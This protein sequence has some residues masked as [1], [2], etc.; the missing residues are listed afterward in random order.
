MYTMLLLEGII[1]DCYWIAYDYEPLKGTISGN[2]HGADPTPYSKSTK[3]CKQ[4]VLIVA[5]IM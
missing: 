4:L 3:L 5:Y 2:Q 1:W